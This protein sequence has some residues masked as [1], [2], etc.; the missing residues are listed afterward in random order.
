MKGFGLGYRTRLGAAGGKA[1]F[2]KLLTEVT[3]IIDMQV[4]AC[5]EGRVFT[6]NL[7]GN[8]DFYSS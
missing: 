8:A 7:G 2:R 1:V 6:L 5:S 4:S 3:V